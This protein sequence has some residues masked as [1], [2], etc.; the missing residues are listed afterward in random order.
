[1]DQALF[2]DELIWA[3]LLTGISLRLSVGLVRSLWTL[4]GQINR[5]L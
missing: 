4:L 1:M 3:G 2:A 5:G